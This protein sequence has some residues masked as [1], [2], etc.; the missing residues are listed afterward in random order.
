MKVRG[1]ECVVPLCQL[2]TSAA[3]CWPYNIWGFSEAK[4]IGAHLPPEFKRT[5]KL[6]LTGLPGSDESGILLQPFWCL[7][8]VNLL[9]L[10]GQLLNM[11]VPPDLPE[12]TDVSTEFSLTQWKTEGWLSCWDPLL[13]KPLWS[14]L[15]NSQHTS[16]LQILGTSSNILNTKYHHSLVGG[17]SFLFCFELFV[18]HHSAHK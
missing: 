12:W 4:T 13:S 17:F 11:P 5:Q 16:M 1:T 6:K 7:D 18:T 8:Y 15:W 3:K 10:E 2:L 14:C 9:N